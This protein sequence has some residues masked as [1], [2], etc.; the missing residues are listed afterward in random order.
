MYC[1]ILNSVKT[2]SDYNY[3]KNIEKSNF[4][5]RRNYLLI[6]IVWYNFVWN[7]LQLLWYQLTI[8]NI[9]NKLPQLKIILWKISCRTSTSLSYSW[10]HAV[11]NTDI[12]NTRDMLKWYGYHL[13]FIVT[14]FSIGWKIGGDFV[15]KNPKFFLSM[16]YMLKCQR[17]L[18]RH[19]IH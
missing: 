18:K 16:T 10:V 15:S 1:S 17:I 4:K 13:I 12:S 5:D 11:S 8:F 14:C 9:H 7:S 19:R 3:I 6:N 2:F